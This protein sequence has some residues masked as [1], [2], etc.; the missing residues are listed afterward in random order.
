MEKIG[1]LIVCVFLLG[2]CGNADQGLCERIRILE[3][4][5]EDLRIDL[6]RSTKMTIYTN[7]G[8]GVRGRDVNDVVED[9]L[10]HLNLELK[11]DPPQYTLTP[12]REE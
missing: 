10:D 6:N 3:Q 2:S 5:T 9:I 12:I 4:K 7:E 8:W 1:L 11:Y